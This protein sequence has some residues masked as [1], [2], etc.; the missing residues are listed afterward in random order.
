MSKSAC[1][2]LRAL[3]WLTAAYHLVAGLA[4]TV[5]QQYAV[6][7]G[8]FMYGI[9]VT[10]TAQM[11]LVV[12]YLGVFGITVGVLAAFAALDPVGNRKII[13]GLVV[14][15]LVRAIDRIVFY[16]AMQEFHVG[17][18]PAWARIIII[19]AFAMAFVVLAR[20]QGAD[21]ERRQS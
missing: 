17:P 18:V 7:L 3:L 19:L 16:K 13:Y 5:A 12:R 6:Q 20:R 21:E 9:D 1:P 4:A 8:A 15:F 2:G 10:L 14:Y 11:E